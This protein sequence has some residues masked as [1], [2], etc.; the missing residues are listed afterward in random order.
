MIGV[1]VMVG[2][3][4]MVMVGVAVTLADGEGDEVTGAVTRLRGACCRE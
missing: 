2:F 3:A 4:V 1:A